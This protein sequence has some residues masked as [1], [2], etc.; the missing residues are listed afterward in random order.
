MTCTFLE[1][2]N[3][4]VPWR[5]FKRFQNTMEELRSW[6]QFQRD[7]NTGIPRSDHMHVEMRDLEEERDEEEEVKP[8]RT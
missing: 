1:S 6:L 3:Q 7:G 2:T 5:Y 8:G 4:Q